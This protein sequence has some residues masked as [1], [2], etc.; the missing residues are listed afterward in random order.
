M[1]G[2]RIHRRGPHWYVAQVSSGQDPKTGRRRRITLSGKTSA[3][4]R[5]KYEIVQ[6]Q[7]RLGMRRAPGKESFGAYL[8]G[9]VKIC[10]EQR[11]PSTAYGYRKVV[12]QVCE[13]PLGTVR[14]CDL[15]VDHLE[16]YYAA[17]SSRGLSP[18]GIRAQHRVLRA[19]LNRARKRGLVVGDPAF[20]ADLPKAVPYEARIYDSEQMRLFLGEASRTSP[21]FLLYVVEVTCGWRQSE[22]VGGRWQDLAPDGVFSVRQAFVRVPKVD[23]K[24][25]FKAP[26]TTRSRRPVVVPPEVL[27]LLW[28]HRE[29]QQRQKALLGD[30]YHDHDLIFCQAN[31]KPLHARNL[32]ERDFKPILKRA[33]L[34]P[35]PFKNLRASH[36]SHLERIG[37]AMSV[38]QARA[39]HANPSTTLGHYLRPVADQQR[40][41]AQRVAADLG[42]KGKR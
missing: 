22:L 5:Q 19:A 35:I 18:N 24:K 16:A 11:A 15:E 41:A 27:E 29:E 7:R 2:L 25:Y 3:E 8:L 32:V 34:P 10:E 40:E 1:K 31:G 42:L 38:I 14:L 26:K 12:N 17:L 30:A 9:W 20:L 4:V 33:G 21:H 36:L 6:A 39:G 37:T 28:E 13:A 23:P